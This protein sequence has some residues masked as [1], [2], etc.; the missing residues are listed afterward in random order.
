M[1]F[2]AVLETIPAYGW[3][4]F[5]ANLTWTVAYDT[6]YAMVDRE[7]DLKIGI[8]STAILFGSL[9]RFMIGLSFDLIIKLS[10]RQNDVQ[11]RAAVGWA[12]HLYLA[13]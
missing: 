13:I 6:M 11:A 1:A 3:W 10:C 5:V 7:D 9:D 2:M 4:L 8:K 12:L